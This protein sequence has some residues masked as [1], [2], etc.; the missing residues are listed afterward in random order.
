MVADTHSILA[1]WRNYFFQLLNVHGYN[2]VRQTEIHTAEP[3]IPEPSA[4]EVEFAIEELKSHKSTGIDQIPA[5]FIK[6]GGK[7]IRSENHKLIISIWRN[8]LRSR[9]NRSLYLSIRRA[10]KQI[11]EIVGAYQS[12]QLRTK[13]Y[14][15]SCC[16][17]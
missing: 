16:L 11:V 14:P 6:A 8:C 9:R 7:I 10:I 2:E 5:E 13:V 4:S 3:L 1:R 12:C 17:S 15:T